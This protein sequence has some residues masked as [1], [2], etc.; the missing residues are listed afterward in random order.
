M[1]FRISDIYTKRKSCGCDHLF[2]LILSID[3]V[4]SLG[5]GGGDVSDFAED[6]RENMVASKYDF[7]YQTFRRIPILVANPRM[8]SMS[9]T[10]NIWLPSETSQ[11]ASR[12]GPRI[13]CNACMQ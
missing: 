12:P 6:K 10:D 13:A 2:L 3:H 11:M 1:G 4:I 7:G 8:F 9:I 5:Y